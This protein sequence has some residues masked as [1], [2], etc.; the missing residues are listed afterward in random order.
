M[1]IVNHKWRGDIEH[2]YCRIC[3]A[4]IFKFSSKEAERVFSE[5]GLCEKCQKRLGKEGKKCSS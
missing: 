2:I 5:T 1:K 3:D 4:V